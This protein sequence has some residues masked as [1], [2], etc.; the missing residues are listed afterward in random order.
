MTSSHNQIKRR[1]IK[2]AATLIVSTTLLVVSTLIIIF[3]ANYG[4]MQ[5]K[6]TGN[7]LRFNQAY[8]AAEAGL[9][10]GINYLKHNSATILANPVGGFVPAYSDANITNSA[11]PDGSRYTS[12]STACETASP[13]KDQPFKTR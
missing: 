6:A 11:L 13:I 10:F 4:M 8:Q 7:T 5:D 9:E 3:A 2:G 12:A 1:R